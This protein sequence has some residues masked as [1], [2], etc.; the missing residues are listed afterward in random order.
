[1][2]SE[3]RSRAPRYGQHHAPRK[4]RVVC[5][6]RM[7]ARLT[8]SPLAWAS[9]FWRRSTSRAIADSTV[10]RIITEDSKRD[11]PHGGYLAQTVLQSN[12]IQHQTPPKFVPRE[13]FEAKNDKPFH[14]ANPVS[15]RHH[16]TRKSRNSANPP[17]RNT[18]R[19]TYSLNLK[20]SVQP[21]RTCRVA[22]P[23]GTAGMPRSQSQRDGENT[24]FFVFFAFHPLGDLLNRY[25]SL[26]FRRPK[27]IGYAACSLCPQ[28]LTAFSR[29]NGQAPL[30]P[31]LFTAKP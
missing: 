17:S 11:R 14:P 16:S 1:M 5:S 6:E 21:R 9:S 25:K 27:G 24:C 10:V 18:P 22:N 8:I 15:S 13:R 26:F 29:L 19:T 2:S 28:W 30:S 7:R 12:R 20:T 4:V 23:C 31:A 3:I